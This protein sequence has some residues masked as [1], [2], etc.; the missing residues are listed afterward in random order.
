M[1]GACC[2]LHKYLMTEDPDD[3]I[4]KEVDR[5]LAAQCMT[6]ANERVQRDDN[7][8]AISGQVIRDQIAN[9]M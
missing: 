3:A 9:Q 8:G 2:I 6:S 7:E 5:E 1:I 4:M